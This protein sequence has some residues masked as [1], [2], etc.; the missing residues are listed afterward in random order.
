MLGKLNDNE[1]EKL[2]G[3]QVI[4]RLGCHADGK[5][6]VLPISYAYDGR[7]IYCHTEEGMKINIMRSNP[8]VCFQVDKM[9]SMANWQS[10]IEWGSFEELK[11]EQA[12]NEALK[13]LT[14]RALP[15]LSSETTHLF[16][17]WPFPSEDLGT[18]GGIVFR[19][20]PT[21]K[22][23]RFESNQQSTHFNV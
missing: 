14:G 4:G 23:G 10:V 8:D 21:E 15:I 1:I 11:D 2:L 9:H 12:R 20:L 7:Y 16:P 19:I 22:T 5:I 3:S 17:H 13:I 18:I 6:Y